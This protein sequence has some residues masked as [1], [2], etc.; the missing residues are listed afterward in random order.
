M[1]GGWQID[2][3]IPLAVLFALVVQTSGIVWWAA[4]MDARVVRLEEQVTG[5]T[6]DRYRA[7]RAQSDF[8]LRDDR[9]ARNAGDIAAIN[10]MIISLDIK[11]DKMLEKIVELRLLLA[12]NGAEQ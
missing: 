10:G 1:T 3:H 8:R 2:K 5:G 6:D 7:S 9:I 11:M 4:T 12:K